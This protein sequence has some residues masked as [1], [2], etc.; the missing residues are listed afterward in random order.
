MTD[1]IDATSDDA[2][3]ERRRP[4]D[5][6]VGAP[7]GAGGTTT[8][9][10]SGKTSGRTFG[11]A[12]VGTAGGPSGGAPERRAVLRLR[13]AE[14]DDAAGVLAIYA[15]I[16]RETS[17]SFE[18]EPPSVDE[19]SAR[20]ER[21]LR[22]HPWIVMAVESAAAAGDA[23]GAGAPEGSASEGNTSEGSTPSAG[24]APIA[25][26]AYAGAW[27][28]RAAYGW[29]AEVSAY[30]HAAHRGRGVA[31]TLY[32]TL[33]GLL[34]GQGLRTLVAG[35]TLPNDASD[36]LHRA[37]G[38][39][40]VGDFRRVGRKFDRWHDVRWMERSLLEDGDADAPPAPLQPVH[41][42]LDAWRA[43]GMPAGG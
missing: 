24:A 3:G 1:A 34:R 22:T 35:L 29:T 2:E 10:T 25:G 37:V 33:F 7:D 5:V 32:E 30:V 43:R 11:R 23:S 18:L 16:V 12:R 36:T 20:I 21:T 14:P 15:P 26:Y 6:G 19:M 13:V 38:F 28:T 40:H 4:D 27:R 17:I 41:E 39:T 31:R 8:G 9:E 42:V